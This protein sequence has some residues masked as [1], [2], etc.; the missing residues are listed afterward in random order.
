M[1]VMVL[2]LRS[3]HRPRVEIPAASDHGLPRPTAHRALIDPPGGVLMWFII[4]LELFSFAI[5]CV[6]IAHLRS[7]QS[8]V[9]RAGQAALD[10][11]VGLLL[12]LSLVTS[13]WLVAEAVHAYR[14]AHFERARRFYFGAIG[15]GLAFVGL[16]LHDYSSKI[17]AGHGLGVNDF[18]DVYLLATGFHFVHVLVGL[19]LL[20]YVGTR[21]RQDS[22]EDPETAFVGT[23]LFWHMCDAVWFL[24]FP[25]FFARI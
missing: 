21:V 9:F 2:W 19:A 16:K 5:I 17:R 6:G 25:L 22:F 14:E 11:R 10:T 23:A 4:T 18:W 20:A 8:A 13:G 3:G 12:T 7:S 24:L 15:M 1:D